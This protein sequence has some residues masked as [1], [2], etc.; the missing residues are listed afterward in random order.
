MKLVSRKRSN[1]HRHRH[2]H[3]VGRTA[4]GTKPP[5]TSGGVL[6]ALGSHPEPLR[7]SSTRGYG[8]Q[9]GFGGGVLGPGSDQNRLGNQWLGQTRPRLSD[10]FITSERRARRTDP[11][12]PGTAAPPPPRG[13]R[14]T[15]PHRG[16]FAGGLLFIS[17][18]PAGRG[19]RPDQIRSRCRRGEGRGGTHT[20]AFHAPDARTHT[21]TPVLALGP[22][23]PY[24]PH[25]YHTAQSTTTAALPLARKWPLHPLLNPRSCLKGSWEEPQSSQAAHTHLV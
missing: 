14:C 3:S 21:R 9:P 16:G 4:A 19:S 1:K 23:A 11:G 12:T 15:A 22:H 17:G 6:S 25:S 18:R 7:S 8:S 5:P 20:L 13:P 2:T 24:T 10:Q